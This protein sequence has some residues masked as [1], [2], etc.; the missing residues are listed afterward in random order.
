MAVIQ[1][2]GLREVEVAARERTGHT[3]YGYKREREVIYEIPKLV[4]DVTRTYKKKRKDT[5]T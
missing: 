1:W 5:N 3:F 4:D 2:L